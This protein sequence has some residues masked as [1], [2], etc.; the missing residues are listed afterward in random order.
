ME[1]LAWFGTPV[2]MTVLLHLILFA[3]FTLNFSAPQTVT[4]RIIKPIAIQAQLVSANALM[5]KT[6][7]TAKPLKKKPAKPKPTAKPQASIDKPPS[8]VMQAPAKIEPEPV[9]KPDS[10]AQ[11]ASL[12]SQSLKDVEA[13]LAMERLSQ[14]GIQGSPS[15][16]VAA[17]VQRAVINRWTRPPSARNGMRAVIEIALVPTGDV[18]GVT[19]LTSSGNTAFDR[20][21]VNAIEKA[22][23][24][25]EVQQLERGLFERDFRRFQLIFRPEDLRY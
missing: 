3:A 9:A 22:A 1:R 25:P 11:E 24:F 8:P 13:A 14:E 6:K 19:V 2:L 12:N 18:V 17:L 21:A 20:S 23:R 5:P 10:K 16:T 15:D 7:P 4:A